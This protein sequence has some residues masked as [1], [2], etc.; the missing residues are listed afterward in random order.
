MFAIHDGGTRLTRREVLRLGGLG[1]LGTALAP[2]QKTRAAGLERRFGQAKA[3]I[4]LFLTGGP[5]QHETWDPKPDAPAEIRGPFQP[6]A[7][8][9]P[10]LHVCELMP[11]VARVAHH[12][13]VLRALSTND[14]AHSSS[15]YWMLTGYPHQPLNSESSRPGAPNDWPCFGAMVRRLRREHGLLPAAVTLPD[16]IVN[17]PNNPWPGQDGGFLGRSADPWLL[18]C[19]PAAA[20]FRVPEL[21]LPAEMPPLRFDQRRSLLAQVDRHL[22][23]VETHSSLALYQH[24]ARQAFA[25]LRAPAVRR[26]FEIDQ[27]PA[28][29]RERYGRSR[30]GQSVLLA[31]RLIEAGVPLVQVNWQRETGDAAASNPLWDTHQKNAERLKD[32]LM[33]QMDLGYSALLEDLAQRGLLDETLVVWMGEFGRTPR[34]NGAGG[35]DHWGHVFSVALAGGGV[36]GGRVYGA[37]DRSGGQPRD[38]RV[39]PQDLTATLF[40][41]LGIDPHAEIHDALGRPVAVSRGEVVRALF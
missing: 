25:L 15:G 18:S 33:P 36:Q 41:C 19:D 21:S 30:F 12:C 7:T 14:N 31:R 24:Q 28:A 38:G 6:I 32:V 23:T 9:V 17:N 27:E 1:L 37:S 2:E 16:R 3:C 8:S 34:I 5:P 29:V 40:H 4:L 39:Q 26:A 11:R 20:E 10:G 22:D 35:R 13:S